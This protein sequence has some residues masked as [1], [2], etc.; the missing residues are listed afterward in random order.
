ASRALTVTCTTA[1]AFGPAIDNV[2]VA[3]PASTFAEC[4]TGGWQTAFDGAGNGFKNQGDCVSY[5]A[6]GGKNPGA[7]APVAP[8]DVAATDSELL[9]SPV[10]H[11]TKHDV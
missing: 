4:K 11:S 2:S 9:R 10:K 1:G 3:G 7:L 8:A 5:V 6:T